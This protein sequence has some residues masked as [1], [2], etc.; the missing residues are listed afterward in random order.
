M[1]DLEIMKA[2]FKAFSDGKTICIELKDYSNQTGTITSFDGERITIAGQDIVLA[3]IADIKVPKIKSLSEVDYV[4]ETHF[5]VEDIVGLKLSRIVIS[6]NFDNVEVKEKGIIFDINNDKIVLITDTEKKILF[7]NNITEIT[8]IDDDEI[9][10]YQSSSDEYKVTAFEKALIEGQ[11]DIVDGYFASL[12]ALC[13]DGYTEEEAKRIISVS[14]NPAPWNDEDKNRTYNQ[15]R[16]LF[17][18]IGNRGRTAEKLFVQSISEPSLPIS[19]KKKAVSTLLDIL[20]G[21]SALELSSFIKNNIDIITG[22]AVLRLKAAS[23]LIKGRNYTTAR[24]LVD[25]SCTDVDFSDILFSLKFYEKNEHFDPTE[26]EGVNAFDDFV[27]FKELKNLLELPNKNACIQLLTAYEKTERFDSFFALLDLFMPYARTENKIVSL[28]G[29]CLKKAGPSEYLDRYLSEFPL[30]WLDKTLAEMYAS[31]HIFSQT[32]NK[33]ISRL[34]N[35]CKRSRL[36]GIPNTFEDAV[37]KC[38]FQLCDVLRSN[39]GIMTSLG[40]SNNEIDK[41]RSVE[42]EY[43]KYSTKPIIEKL[44]FLEGNKDYIPESTAAIDFLRAPEAVSK[45]LFP[46]LINDGFGG[47]VYELFNYTPYH[48]KKLSALK[49]FYLKALLALNEKEEYWTEVKNDWMTLGLDDQMLLAVAEIAASK[50]DYEKSEAIKTYIDKPDFNEMED[51]LIS[52]EVSRLRSLSV[53]ADVLTNLDYTSDEI[54]QIQSSTRSKMDFISND[55]LSIANRIYAFQKNKNRTAELFYKLALKEDSYSAALG[56][57]SIYLEEGRFKE[58]CECFEIYL[59]E[60]ATSLTSSNKDSYL[61]A[62]Y[63]SGQYEKMRD[64][65]LNEIQTST[66]DLLY[67]LNALLEIPSSDYEIKLLMESAIQV[68]KNNYAVALECALKLCKRAVSEITANAIIVIYNQ[69]FSIAD[70]ETILNLCP[71]ITHSVTG[72]CVRPYG[73]G[74][75]ALFEDDNKQ[76]LHEWFDWMFSCVT[77]EDARFSIIR[78]IAAIYGTSDDIKGIIKDKLINMAKNGAVLPDDLELYLY[79]KFSDKKDMISWLDN[80]LRGSSDIEELTFNLFVKYSNELNDIDRIYELLVKLAHSQIN[81]AEIYLKAVFDTLSIYVEE[82]RDICLVNNLLHCFLQHCAQVFLKTEDLLILYR[83]YF[84]VGKN[85]YVYLVR[86]VLNS[87]NVDTPNLYDENTIKGISFTSIVTDTLGKDEVDEIDNLCAIFGKYIKTTEDDAS[88]LGQLKDYYNMPEKWPEEA[89]E[90]LMKYFVG[91]ASGSF[92]WQ[93]LGI[94][95]SNSISQ[96]K[97]NIQFHQALV[98]NTSLIP[99]LYYLTNNNLKSQTIGVLKHLFANMSPKTFEEIRDTVSIL[100]KKNHAWLADSSAAKS[101]IAVAITN[102][103][104]KTSPITW[105]EVLNIIIDVA[106]IGK[107]EEDFWNIVIQGPDKLDPSIV[108]K[109]VCVLLLK[110]NI[111]HV[112]INSVIKALEINASERPYSKLLS[113][114]L[115]QTKYNGMLSPVQIEQLKIVNC[116]TGTF[117]NE[118]AIY[119]YYVDAGLDVAGSKGIAEDALRKVQEYLPEMG[120]FDDIRKYSILSENITDENLINIYNDEYKGLIQLVDPR[121]RQKVIMNLIPGEIYLKAKGYNVQSAYIYGV[122]V[123]SQAEILKVREEKELYDS[124]DNIFPHEKYPGLVGVFLKCC[125]TRKWIEFLNYSPEDSDI[126]QI[127]MKD[128]SIKEIFMRRSHDIIKSAVLSVIDGDPESASIGRRAFFTAYLTPGFNRGTDFRLIQRLPNEDKVVLR[129]IFSLR[130]ESKTLRDTGIIGAAILKIPGSERIAEFLNI[131]KTNILN[132]LFNNKTSFNVLLELEK[133]KATEIANTYSKLFTQGSD[134]I[135]TRF[136]AQQL[137]SE[138]VS[139]DLDELFEKTLDPCK[140]KRERYLKIKDVVENGDTYATR[141]DFKLFNIAKR[142]Y[143]YEAVI[144]VSENDLL[145]ADPIPMDYCSVITH[146]FNKNLMPELKDYLWKI[147][148]E[149]LLPALSVVLTLLEQYPEAYKVAMK[150]EDERWRIPVLQILISTMGYNKAFPEDE[151]LTESLKEILHGNYGKILFKWFPENENQKQQYVNRMQSLCKLYN[152]FL[153]YLSFNG[154]DVKMVSYNSERFE[155]SINRYSSQPTVI[156]EKEFETPKVIG[157]QSD[158]L[159]NHISENSLYKK[160]SNIST[161]SAIE[162]T[163]KETPQL[164]E[165]ISG[166]KYLFEAKGSPRDK[167]DVLNARML[168]RWMYLLYMYDNGYSREYLNNIL[169]LITSEDDVSYAQWTA[170]VS[171]LSQYFDE[172]ASIQQL[173]RVVENDIVFLQNITVVTSSSHIK[174]LRQL[175]KQSWS[176]IIEVLVNIAGIDFTRTVESEQIS[177]LS[178]CRSKLL[179]DRKKFGSSLFGDINDRLLHLIEEQIISLRNTPDLY[180]NIVGETDHNRQ[181]ILWEDGNDTGKLYAIVSNNGGADCNQVTLTSRINMIKEHK[182]FINKVYSGEKIPFK[183]FFTSADLANGKATWDIVLSYYDQS[184]NQTIT[185]THESH[186][187]VEIGGEPFDLGNISTG[188]PARGE[189][190][191]GRARELAILRN[192]YSNIEQLPSMLIRGLKRSGKSSILIKFAEEMKKKNAFMVAFVDGQ[193]IG[194]KLKTAFI[195]KI[196]DSLRISYRGD[197]MYGDIFNCRFDD[198]RREWNNK[199][200]SS[201][202]IGQLDTFY[203]ELSQLFGKKILIII[204]EMESIFYNHRFESIQ[205]EENLYAVLRS[206]IQRPENYVSFVICGSDKLLTSCLEQNRESQMFQTLQYLEVGHMNIGDIKEIYRIQSEKYDI[207][208]TPDAVDTIWQ[209]THGLVWYAKLLGYLVINNIMSH[210]LTIRKEVNRSDIM[211]AIQMLINGEI[212]NDKYDLVDSSLNTSRTAIVHAMAGLMPDYNKPLSVDEIFIAL[213]SMRK[214]GYINPRNGELIPKMDETTV[215]G[216]LD[217]LE[218]MQFIDANAARTKYLFTAELYRLFFRKDKKLHLF[219]ERSEKR[220]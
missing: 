165:C 174:F 215:K 73:S 94:Y 213:E 202:W 84:Y 170:I 101:I 69:L 43:F 44:L 151:T 7:L 214:E 171:Y 196:F 197:S 79:P 127:L 90:S 135:F 95:N 182:Y 15:A 155:A 100:I 34:L 56:L 139:G 107:I 10:Y 103:K 31:S 108:E 206:L 83:A 115:I 128:S 93:L 59:K 179:A 71:N 86:Y 159:R 109:F 67:V 42:T 130:I 132:L 186:I 147:K 180:I 80:I 199:L 91:N 68:N 153:L 55:S 13:A 145:L 98:N 25:E 216:H 35:Q 17:T 125:F 78:N 157:E 144:N 6:Y 37:I 70:T 166:L 190:F 113:D 57:L 110:R 106:F 61:I 208:F 158:L 85:N 131:Y 24:S 149:A 193:S 9:D 38:N 156:V 22:N 219:E 60:N 28:V 142:E 164:G 49:M 58:L 96:V 104:L 217:F 21:E 212:G 3:D 87:R 39:D 204:D 29:Q 123:L 74:I 8:K 148:S 152:D 19:Q 97:G 176:N 126:N 105:G 136:L 137:N 120:V 11:K 66:V 172:V 200:E 89:I 188:N 220:Q 187:S 30:L 5:S 183:A 178:I 201:D 209:F 4:L 121:R 53:D 124:L 54:K 76:L 185:L 146:L 52:G 195:D 88:N 141:K 36:Y 62:L 122:R 81:Y 26:L 114:I 47:I 119:Q 16:R 198:F 181:R 18:Y 169:E 150:L 133:D 138:V 191:V 140:E 48:S 33:K 118:T 111:N 41:I 2:L 12:E 82:R 143:L 129:K 65:W 20:G 211:T 32:D 46:L 27:G 1:N 112:L 168:L 92:C 63:H 161:F 173:R 99:V 177:R 218:K 175:D 134:N 116:S 167:E 162:Y 154:I 50:G 64:Y 210:D 45:V 207:D 163:K 184:K 72:F 75:V 203:Y 194:S 77:E 23:L 192:H 117:I 51:A 205:Q 102:Q 189:S 40:Y 160:L 14:K